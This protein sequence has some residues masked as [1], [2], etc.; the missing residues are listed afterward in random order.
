MVSLNLNKIKY[1]LKEKSQNS[2]KTIIKAYDNYRDSN[3]FSDLECPQCKHKSLTF[4]KTYERNLTYDINNK[5]ENIKINII[6]CQCQHCVQKHNKQKYHAILPEFILPY[7]IYESSSIINAINEY[8]KERELKEILKRLQITHKLFYDWLKKFNKYKLSASIVLK[9]NNEINIVI[10]EI[11][12]SNSI[13]LNTFY[14]INEHP[15]F[16]FKLTC[17]PLCI[18]P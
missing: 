2:M 6:V 5:I 13:F 9:C 8:L 7:T 16:L 12:K 4:H 11:I 1:Y 18:I 17:V 3:D 14:E 10:S 15:F